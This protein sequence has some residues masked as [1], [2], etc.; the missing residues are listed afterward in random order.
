MSQIDDFTLPL[1]QIFYGNLLMCVA[2]AFYLVWWVLSRG[3]T[4]NNGA[5][6]LIVVILLF[7]MAAILTIA[8]GINALAHEG[9]GIPI[10]YFLPGTAI[11]FI[12][13]LLSTEI[14]FHRMVTS[15]LLLITVW[16]AIETAAITALKRS[17]RFSTGSI[18]VLVIFT[19]I[20]FATGMVCYI[21]HYR[22]DEPA[23][24]WNGLIPLVM[25]GGVGALFMLILALFRSSTT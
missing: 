3:C 20:A 23:R 12:I 9:N 13:L 21:I 19:S 22:L 7:G 4:V 6:I 17:G 18:A 10:F 11:A 25:D 24:F 15:E 16:T 14:V 2:I 5:D 1:R 8:V